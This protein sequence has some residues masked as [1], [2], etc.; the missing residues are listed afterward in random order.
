[1]TPTTLLPQLKAKIVVDRGK[2]I[3]AAITSRF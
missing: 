1:M 3:A 2:F